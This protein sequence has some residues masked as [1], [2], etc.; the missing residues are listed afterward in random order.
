MSFITS[1]N[2]NILIVA[3]DEK[4]FKIIWNSQKMTN[5]CA[6]WAGEVID[7][8]V[9]KNGDGHVFDD[10]ENWSCRLRLGGYMVKIIFKH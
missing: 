1:T 2:M 8:Y 5:W 3:F 9:F 10:S 7:W 6:F 4:N